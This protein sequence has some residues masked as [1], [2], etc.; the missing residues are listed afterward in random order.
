[1]FLRLNRLTEDM[2]AHLR[3]G[4]GA[5]KETFLILVYLGEGTMCV[6]FG[7]AYFHLT[8][9]P[10]NRVQVENC[11]SSDMLYSC[12]LDDSSQ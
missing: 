9:F 1:M 4:R 6:A 5:N 3:N 8:V 2:I 11:V 7:A 12:L 10:S